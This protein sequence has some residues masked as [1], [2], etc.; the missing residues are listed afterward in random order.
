MK[1]KKPADTVTRERVDRKDRFGADLEILSGPDQPGLNRAR[2]LASLAAVEG[3]RHRYLDERNH[4]IERRAEADIP[5]AVLEI[6][7]T[8]FER[9]P[10]IENIGV[11]V[12]H[13]GA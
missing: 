1:L 13:P 10:V 11:G 2:G 8:I 12:R 6:F 4:A 9:K 5:D 3:C 7:E